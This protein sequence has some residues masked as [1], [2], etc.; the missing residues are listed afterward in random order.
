MKSRRRTRGDSP[1]MVTCSSDWRSR[2]YRD[3]PDTCL[4]ADFVPSADLRCCATA[5]IVRTMIRPRDAPALT[6]P[7]NN[8]E[9][10]EKLV[11]RPHAWPFRTWPNARLHDLPTGVCHGEHRFRVF[12]TLVE[13]AL[14]TLDGWRNEQWLDCRDRAQ[15]RPWTTGYGSPR[16]G[17]EVKYRLTPSDSENDDLG[18]MVVV[19]R[20][21]FGPGRVTEP[22]LLPHDV[23]GAPRAA[24]ARVR[25][26]LCT[27]EAGRVA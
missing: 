6:Y 13:V 2:E 12:I 21:D 3:R 19:I 9:A 1:V 17:G 24:L 20:G 22:R 4:S 27:I 16:V 11:E 23:G 25:R 8:A 18:E 7:T 14:I 15:L 26:S 5:S 10:A